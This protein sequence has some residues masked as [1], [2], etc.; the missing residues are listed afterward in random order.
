MKLVLSRKGFDSSSGGKPNPIM[1]DGSLVPLPIPDEAAPITYRDIRYSGGRLSSLVSQLTGGKWG[2]GDGAHLDPDL[3]RKSLPRSPQWRPLFG[4]MGAAGGHLRKMAVG[5]GDLFLFF[6]WFRQTEA[7]GRRY[8]YKKG[9]PGL[10]VLFGWL[11]VDRVLYAPEIS[12]LPGW[13]QHH[14]HCFGDRGKNNTFY[15]ARRELS[16][17]GVSSGIPGAGLFPRLKPQL[18]LTETGKTRGHWRLPSWF[19]PAGRASTLSYHG[20][21]GRW[22]RTADGTT[23]RSVA[24][25]QEY[26][27][28]AEHYPELAPWVISLLAACGLNRRHALPSNPN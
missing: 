7:D 8:F 9:A 27:L 1:P 17:P 21:R 12:A 20:D 19:H 23:L 26:V 15:L 5:A 3:D 4:Q 13:M 24:R 22:T 18:I 25:G 11:Q 14:P 16:L 28:R 6:G 10:H 2:A